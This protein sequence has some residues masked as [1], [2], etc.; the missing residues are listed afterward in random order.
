MSFL[1]F[2]ASMCQRGFLLTVYRET[3]C[4]VG[5]RCTVWSWTYIAWT[6]RSK[7]IST[8]STLTAS[9]WHHVTNCCRST[10]W[11]DL[12]SINSWSASIASVNRFFLTEPG[13]VTPS[14]CSDVELQPIWHA[15]LRSAPKTSQTRRGFL[16]VSGR[17]IQYTLTV[18]TL[19]MCLQWTLAD[20]VPVVKTSWSF[21]VTFAISFYSSMH[22]TTRPPNLIFPLGIL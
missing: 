5:T 12:R 11:L 3:M 10:Q 7:S 19:S 20:N 1:F 15:V 18:Y 9:V 6:S 13:H 22:V 17:A 8:H 14:T 16:T 2:L 21:S 4:T